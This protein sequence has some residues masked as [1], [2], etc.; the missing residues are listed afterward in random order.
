MLSDT[1]RRSRLT[2]IAALT[3]LIALALLPA[4]A[5]ASWKA[6]ANPRIDDSNLDVGQA[7]YFLSPT[8]GW[9]VGDGPGVL[10]TTDG[11]ASWTIQVVPMTH[12]AW[13]SLNAVKFTDSLH[14]VASGN[15]G[16]YWTA[17]GGGTWNL[18]TMTGAVRILSLSY[19]TS[20]HVW[21]ADQF[22]G[23]YHSDDGGHT[24]ST[25]ETTPA[26]SV[27]EQLWSVSFASASEGWACG[28][29]GGIYHTSDGGT[30]WK[31]QATG[32]AYRLPAIQ[33]IDSDNGWAVGD[34][35]TILHTTDGGQHWDTQTSPVASHFWAVDFR[36]ANHGAI[37]GS[38]GTY[39]YTSD[40]G[41]TWNAENVGESLYLNGVAA[42]TPD[43]AY[44]VG[45]YFHVFKRDSAPSG[46]TPVSISRSPSKSAITCKR[47]KGVAKFT[48]KATFT[49]AGLPD[50]GM[51]VRLQTSSNGKSW[52][53][54]YKLKT[55]AS[56]VAAKAFS[57]KKKSTTYYRW[58]S[59]ASSSHS[60]AYSSRFKVIV[61]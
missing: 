47:K 18:A 25:V 19:A 12:V 28:G 29:A 35:T 39:L 7:A 13:G 5:N 37:V 61:K 10:Q 22:Q 30:T 41:T 42:P 53:A 33:F 4:T 3:V 15:D 50:G 60:V 52:K 17:D 36:D 27:H 40:G 38:S 26:A 20:S 32:T 46:S 57:A 34:Y 44:A 43:V 55:N 23:L 58:C 14:G 9:I 49:S 24:W 2:W 21:A 54:G 59:P 56:G 1:T 31:A 16:T 51:A 8:I 6:L 11:G 48:L 45:G